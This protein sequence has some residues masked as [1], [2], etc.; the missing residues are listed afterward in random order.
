[1]AL[2]KQDKQR[3]RHHMGYPEVSQGQTFA[4]G[5]I[6][7]PMELNFMIEGAMNLV[8]PESEGWL[9]QVLTNLDG[10]ESQIIQ[11]QPNLAGKSV[12]NVVVNLDEFK[13]LLQQY[14]YWQGSLSN[15]LAIPANPFD[16]RFASTGINVP[17]A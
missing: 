17:V 13:M 1:M 15:I 5:G 4:V 9:R 10:I 6:P 2:S 11:D 14:G 8:L 3:I 12:G 7:A 16:K